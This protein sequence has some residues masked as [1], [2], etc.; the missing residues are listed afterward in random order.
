M[1]TTLNYGILTRCACIN[2]SSYKLQKKQY[3]TVVFK[4]K[5]HRWIEGLTVNFRIIILLLYRR[6]GFFML[7]IFIRSLARP[8]NPWS[9]ATWFKII[10]APNLIKLRCSASQQSFHCN[11]LDPVAWPGGAVPPRWRLALPWPWAVMNKYFIILNIILQQPLIG[12]P[13]L[14]SLDTPLSGPTNSHLNLAYQLFQTQQV[15]KA[16][17]YRAQIVAQTILDVKF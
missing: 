11:F 2:L 4:Y 6:R 10:T 12:P 8:T 9:S 15:A 1:H 13:N 17:S 5:P 16:I 7:Y 14:Q 3:P